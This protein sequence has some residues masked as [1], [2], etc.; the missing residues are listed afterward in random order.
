MRRA[1]APSGGDGGKGASAGTAAVWCSTWPGS[2]VEEDGRLHGGCR[3][4]S[5]LA[6]PQTDVRRHHTGH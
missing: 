2:G 5:V 6:V 4:M 1:G 3:A